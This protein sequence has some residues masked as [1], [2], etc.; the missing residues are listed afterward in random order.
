MKLGQRILLL[1]VNKFEGTGEDLLAGWVY[2]KKFNPSGELE[3][4]TV[5]VEPVSA[6]SEAEAAPHLEAQSK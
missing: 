3:L 2:S 1:T 6:G 4:I 5:A